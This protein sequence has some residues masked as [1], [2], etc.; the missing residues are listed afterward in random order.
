MLGSDPAGAARFAFRTFE[1]DYYY[2]AVWRT[3]RKTLMICTTVF[4]NTIHMKVKVMTGVFILSLSAVVHIRNFPFMN[5]KLDLFEELTLV[6][7]FMTMHI[8]VH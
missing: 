1:P 3:T 6:C 8:A 5:P 4:L 2:W 7:Q